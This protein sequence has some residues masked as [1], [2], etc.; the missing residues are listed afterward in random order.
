MLHGRRIIYTDYDTVTKEN[1]EQLVND[2]MLVHSRNRQEIEILYDY[3]RGKTAI[4]NK[5]K[6]VREEINHKVCEN[7]AY[8]IERF[9]QGYVFGEA[10]QYVRRENSK[11]DVPDDEISA[12]INALNGYMTDVSKASVDNEL[13]EWL[14]VAGT[15]YRVV[16]PNENW[17]G[18]DSEVPFETYS[19]DPRNTFVVYHSGY[20]HQPVFAVNYVSL[21]DGQTLFTVYTKDRYFRFTQGLPVGEI[22]LLRDEKLPLPVG[23]EEIPLYVGGEIPIIEYPADSPRLGVFEVVLDLLDAINEVQSNR[24]DDIVQFVNQFLAIIGGTISDINWQKANENKLICVPDGVDAK[25]IGAA[26]KNTDVQV[27]KEDLYMA[28]LTI[29]GLPNRNGGTSTSDTGTAVTLRDGWQAAESRAKATEMT[30]KKSEKVFLRI[31][32]DI[33]RKTVGTR[34]KVHDIE[35]HFTRRNY[36]NIVSKAQVLTTMLDNAKIDPELAFTSSGMFV[37]PEAAYLQSKQYVEE[38]ER[39]GY[40]I[41]HTGKSTLSTMPPSPDEPRRQSTD[42][43]SEVQVA[44]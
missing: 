30:F 25:Y 17:S 43:L 44:Y 40:I 34:L 18:D 35:A 12:D 26:M 23:V 3:W 15:S 14:Y 9:F 1:V 24:M 32:L 10:I 42:P 21:A 2:A 19:M 33:L 29:C 28:I 22:Q 41:D 7:R 20:K 38:Q 37:D 11:S 5:T 39:K 27:L 13:A 36:E 4:E 6:E 31:V 16:L 8:E